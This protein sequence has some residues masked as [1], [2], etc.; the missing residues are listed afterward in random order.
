MRTDR[1]HL[2]GTGLW[3]QAQNHRYLKI[4]ENLFLCFC[5]H[6]SC[7]H[8]R[9]LEGKSTK[10][11]YWRREAHPSPA[12]GGAYMVWGCFLLISLG[13]F[14]FCFVHNSVCP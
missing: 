11:I 8:K 2:L 6:L 3:V 12:E 14:G 7:T 13:Q 1:A 4:I 10:N 9:L 5:T